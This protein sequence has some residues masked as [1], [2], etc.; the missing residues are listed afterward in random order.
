MNQVWV[1]R[2]EHKGQKTRGFQRVEENTREMAEKTAAKLRKEFPGSFR[3]VWPDL[4]PDPMTIA[5]W[6]RLQSVE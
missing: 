1:V 2:F 3:V 4:I 6:K 5:D